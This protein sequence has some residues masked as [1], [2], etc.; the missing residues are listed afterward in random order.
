MLD[1]PGGSNV[2]TRIF[3]RKKQENQRQRRC[4]G[5]DQSNTTTGFEE[6]KGAMSQG[7]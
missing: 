1:Y 6:W 4:E 7:M 2:I 3:I 5:R